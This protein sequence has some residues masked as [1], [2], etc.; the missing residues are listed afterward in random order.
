MTKKTQQE[1][2][3]YLIT[4]STHPEF[5]RRITLI[6][7]LLFGMYFSAD[8]PSNIS[9]SSFINRLII[10]IQQPVVF[11]AYH[12]TNNEEIERIKFD[13]VSDPLY[14]DKIKENTYERMSEE[15]AKS[16]LFQ[17]FDL[18]YYFQVIFVGFDDSLQ[19]TNAK[20]TF[21]KLNPIPSTE[22]ETP[23]TSLDDYIAVC[24]QEVLSLEKITSDIFKDKFSSAV[25]QSFNK[26]VNS[27][28][29]KENSSV[30]PEKSEKLPERVR[31]DLF[32]SIHNKI[33]RSSLLLNA[34]GSS[35]DNSPFDLANAFLLVRNYIH[36]QG[37]KRYGLYD[38]NI[39]YVVPE[40]QREEFGNFLT[41]IAANKLDWMHKKGIQPFK[42]RVSKK[43]QDTVVNHLDN[44]NKALIRKGTEGI[45]NNFSSDISHCFRSFS[46][47]VF[48]SANIIHF[49]FPFD[50]G[51]VEGVIDDGDGDNYLRAIT[52]H[53]LFSAMA[54]NIDENQKLGVMLVPIEVNGCVYSVLGHVVKVSS[55]PEAPE[56]YSNPSLWNSVYYFHN[57]INR[58]ERNLRS[59][60]RNRYLK[61][62]FR[63][64]HQEI[65]RASVEEPNTSVDELVNN[66]SEYNKDNQEDRVF[67][68]PRIIFKFSEFDS[69]HDT[70]TNKV[71]LFEIVT[72]D[73]ELLENR[74]FPRSGGFY[75]D[76][77]DSKMIKHAMRELESTVKEIEL[78]LSLIVEA[79]DE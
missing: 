31:D 50:S 55:T 21:K 29:I 64:L 79:S 34:F 14:V 66:L 47:P 68:F 62:V 4:T 40:T 58:V 16:R 56:G 26:L 24:L 32:E 38:Y 28:E 51:T 45:V 74:F 6:K 2:D 8:R 9:I 1:T 39:H 52:G 27:T 36:T 43:R 78:E 42:N 53:Y 69:N 33:K 57:I 19:N 25:E 72:I 18:D 15:E 3:N 65:I 22:H 63:R 30:Q 41:E 37:Y 12:K 44:F 17:V 61:R 76:E 70:N 77:F 67:P 49:T 48:N 71:K 60:L 75:N 13:F 11:V 5:Q 54:N 46:D 10:L 73:I 23:I 7:Q 59:S 20:A 35:I